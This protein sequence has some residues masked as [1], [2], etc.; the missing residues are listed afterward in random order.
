MDWTTLRTQLSGY[1]ELTLHGHLGGPGDFG[2]GESREGHTEIWRQGRR[3]R[4]E[5]DGAPE[6]LC[7]GETSWSMEPTRHLTGL[8]GTPVAAPAGKLIYHGDART[9]VHPREDRD[10]S[11]DDFIRHE[12]EVIAERFQGRDCWTVALKAPRRK[13]G[14]LRMWVDQESGYLL[15]EVNEHPDAAGAQAW[16]EDSEINVPLDDSLFVWDGP[17]VTR[18]EVKAAQKEDLRALEE[19][20]RAWFREH[21]ADGPLRIPATV[22]L[23]PTQCSY[24]EDGTFVAGNDGIIIRREGVGSEA[25]HSVDIAWT[26]DG[27]RTTM[28]VQNRSVVPDV[29][30]RDVLRARFDGGDPEVTADEPAELWRLC[31]Q[32]KEELARTRML[33]H[34]VSDLSP[35]PVTLDLTPTAVPVHDDVT[36]EF[37]AYGEDF[38]LTQSRRVESM[39]KTAM[40]DPSSEL[41]RWSTPDVDCE[42]TVGGLVSV[43]RAGMAAVWEQLHPGVPVDRYSR[44]RPEA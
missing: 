28:R 35:V 37:T 23:S 12:E 14:P 22:D 32:E 24:R 33:A 4:V 15:G 11:G 34:I 9:F 3:L 19:S 42:L 13:V 1:P 10:W 5:V 36:G 26:E 30:L 27:L 6:F 2:D 7:D 20:Q 16:I 41:H 44:Y 18:A 21:I 8:A 38:S 40:N 29:S 17:T 31:R 25:E 43:D 39:G